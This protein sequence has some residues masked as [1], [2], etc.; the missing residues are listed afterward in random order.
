VQKLDPTNDDAA[1][2][3]RKLTREVEGEKI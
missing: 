2:A 1:R 3:V